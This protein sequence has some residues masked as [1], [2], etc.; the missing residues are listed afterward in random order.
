MRDTVS[1]GIDAS[2]LASV[3]A[4]ASDLSL[5]VADDGTV[6]EMM[7]TPMQA[8]EMRLP[9]CSGRPV[10]ESLTGESQAKFNA[11]RSAL[12]DGAPPRR[13]IELNHILP[14]GR[15]LPVRYTLIPHPEGGFLMLGRDLSAVAETQAQLVQAQ[16]S[17]EQGYEARR[18]YDARY[19][20]LLRSVH[21]PIIFASAS[22][23]TI[24]DL[25]EPAASILGGTRESLVGQGL[26]AEFDDCDR[27]EMMDRLMDAAGS[28]TERSLKM[29]A[30]RSG[31]EVELSAQM[32]RAAGE[33]SLLCRLNA[34]ADS[35]ETPAGLARDLGVMFERTADAIL[36]TDLRGEI[37]SCNDA[38]LDLL[39]AAQVA[40]VKAQ[41]ISSYFGRGRVDLNVIVENARR[42]GQMR[43]YA[44]KLLTELGG[45][46]PVEISVTY[47]NDRSNPVLAYLIRDASRSEALRGAQPN[48]AADNAR[49]VMELVGSATLKEIVAE[50]TE[51]VEKMCIETAVSLTRNNRVAAAEMLGLSRQ[52]LYVKLRKYD[53]LDR[54]TGTE[55]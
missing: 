53:L 36:F 23:G 30:R 6:T 44:T 2:Y 49:S 24:S 43:L 33:R 41:N 3:V 31:R 42:A 17:L 32:F 35:L 37:L 50:T 14:H 15:E 12:I 47:L 22:D 21:D 26:A 4:A 52:S 25:N 55:A 18:E 9:D 45:A 5:R 34:R 51:V 13:P 11:A 29:T 1:D 40:E 54:N 27:A 19:R 8:A 28:D 16:M 39:N 7:V 46:T 48:G 38:F 20:L 10:A